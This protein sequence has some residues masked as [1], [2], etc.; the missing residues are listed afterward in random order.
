[1]SLFD[2][3]VHWRNSQSQIYNPNMVSEAMSRHNSSTSTEGP[4]FIQSYVETRTDP[5]D[6]KTRNTQR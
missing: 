6:H 3:A 2:S 1:M 4:Q 5:D